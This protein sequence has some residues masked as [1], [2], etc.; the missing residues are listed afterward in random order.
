MTLDAIPDGAKHT[1]DALAALAAVGAVASILPP[2]AALLSIIWL[3]LQ[4][5]GWIETRVKA[6]KPPQN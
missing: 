3:T 4:I 1:L 2:I 5:Y 6:A